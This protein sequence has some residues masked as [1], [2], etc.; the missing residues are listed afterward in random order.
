MRT[1]TL[2]SKAGPAAAARPDTQQE[3]RKALRRFLARCGLAT[4][5]KRIQIGNMMSG[6]G[7]LAVRCPR[8]SAGEFP[9]G[10]DTGH[11]PPKDHSTQF[12]AQTLCHGQIFFSSRNR[13]A[14]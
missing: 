10:F 4:Q 8:T 2:S 6:S 7:I 14:R 3:G 1:G 11:E 12:I 13:L 5:P 9:A